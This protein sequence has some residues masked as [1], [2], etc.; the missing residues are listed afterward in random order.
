MGNIRLL[1]VDDH[2]MVRQG[3]RLLLGTQADFE[4]AGEAADARTA[5]EMAQGLAPDVV[6][7]DIN[8]PGETGIRATQEI[9]RLGLPIRVLGLSAHEDEAF[10]RE[11]VKAGASGYVLKGATGDELI[12]AIRLVHLGGAYFSGGIA[13]HLESALAR[14]REKVGPTALTTREDEVLDLLGKGLTYQ[15]IA[16]RLGLSA[17]TVATHR[18]NIMRKLGIETKEQLLKYAFSL[19]CC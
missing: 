13:P 17:N 4:I 1:L 2:A 14:G 9:A 7:M 3:L 12:A 6:L 16:A 5:V 10:L 15:T 18:A 19:R 8:L 11:M